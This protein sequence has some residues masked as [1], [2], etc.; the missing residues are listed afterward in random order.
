MSYA[1]L[2][3]L[4]FCISLHSPSALAK[5]K[6]KPTNGPALKGDLQPGLK[7]SPNQV[8]PLPVLLGPEN[9]GTVV[10][11]SLLIDV[12]FARS[13][14]A[15]W[16]LYSFSATQWTWSLRAPGDYAAEC[17]TGSITSKMDVLLQFQGF[18]N[19]A[20]SDASEQPVES[21]YAACIGNEQVSQLNWFSA[22]ELNS[23]PLL[24]PGNH[25]TPTLWRLW[26]KISV[27]PGNS[28]SLYSDHAAINVAILNSTTWID[29][30]SAPD[31]Q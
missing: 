25:K 31:G 18:E 3:I 13:E 17:V 8:N 27:K 14:T 20:S 1:L 29:S 11:E 19:L 4:V 6:D 5:D 12:Q 7:K 28:A 26:N 30:G 21:Y 15:P 22:A 2:L 10:N 24:I 9:H 16:I 23:H